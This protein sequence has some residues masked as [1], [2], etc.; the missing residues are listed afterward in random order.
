MIAKLLPDLL[1]CFGLLWLGT[2]WAR[3]AESSIDETL[4]VVVGAELLT[5]MLFCSLVD[6]ASRLRRAPPLWLGILIV[7]GLLLM[8]PQ[9]PTLLVAAASQGMWVVLPIAWS[10]LERFRE[11]WTLPA[12]PAL[13]KWRRRALTFDR[14][15]VGVVLGAA[16]L[17]LMLGS[18]V[19]G[20]H[21]EF[22]RELGWSVLPWALA[23]FYAIAAFDAWRVHRPAF[24]R[25]PRS[26][27]PAIDRGGVN[28]LDPI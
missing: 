6:V 18:A 23:L 26:L 25:A 2:P 12:A 8:T 9:L 24:E 15:Y 4:I 14:M 16:F 10:L 11:L 3:P 17:V 28:D 5:W 21:G 27:L 22:D 19:F 7:I 13:E 20:E 1:A